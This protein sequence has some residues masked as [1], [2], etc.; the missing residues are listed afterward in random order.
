[1]TSQSITSGQRKQVKRVIEDA[2]DNIL[3]ES[4][5]DKDALQRLLM[6]GGEFQA[7]VAAG[8]SRFTSE[9]SNC[10]LARLILAEDFITPEEIM[11][12]CDMAYT[13]EQLLA[14]NGT[15]PGE[16]EL[17]WCRRNAMIL[18]AGP[19]VHMTLLEVCSA[20]RQYFDS[21][22]VW[23]EDASEALVREDK[24]CSPGWMALRK[25]PVEGSVG[26]SWAA[27]RPLL[28]DEMMVPNVAEAIWAL[29]T[30][31]AVRRIALGNLRMRT[32]SVCPQYRTDVSDLR[33][34]GIGTC[35]DED[36]NTSLGLAAFR[37]FPQR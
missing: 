26:Q 27:Q 24:I 34:T 6:R 7:Y 11:S 20:Y 32:R 1:M 17:K 19:P 25:V 15:V 9:V 28:D 23:F 37:K 4:N 18:V 2:I 12:T 10:E 5:I 21:T 29:A 22:M 13:E 16:K 3:D 30:Y 33:A 14:L 31:R 35:G 8:F 36:R